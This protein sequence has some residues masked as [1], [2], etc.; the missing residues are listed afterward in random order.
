MPA[1]AGSPGRMPGRMRIFL[2]DVSYDEM[3]EILGTTPGSLRVRVHRIKKRRTELYER[4]SCVLK[5]SSKNGGR[6]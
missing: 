2:D 3:S 1:G 5:T 6:R 4:D